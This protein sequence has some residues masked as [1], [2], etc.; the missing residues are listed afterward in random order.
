MNSAIFKSWLYWKKSKSFYER[1]KPIV[2]ITFRKE[3]EFDTKIWLKNV[4]TGVNMSIRFVVP[5]NLRVY[6]L[7]QVIDICCYKPPI[8]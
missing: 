3:K 8:I 2:I 5:D 4:F 6:T 7:K 1:Y